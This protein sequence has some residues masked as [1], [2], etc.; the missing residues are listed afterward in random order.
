MNERA[1]VLGS[2]AQL[3]GI[4]TLP[5]GGAVDRERPALIVLNAGHVHRVGPHRLHVRLNRRVASRGFVAV[6]FD[7]S[8]IGDSPARA[9]HRPVDESAP[10]EVREVMDRIESTL[11]IR[12]FCVAGLS[13]GAVISLA[14]ALVDRRVVGACMMNP[15]VLA[16]TEEWSRHVERLSDARIYARNL[17]Q[18]VSWGKLFSGRTNYRRLARAVWYRLAPRR[19]A[20]QLERVADQARPVVDNLLKLD[21]KV[22]MVFSGKDRALEHFE[23]LLGRGWRER[24]GANAEVAILPDANHTFA[25]PADLQ[26]AIDAVESWMLRCWPA[27]GHA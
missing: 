12:R 23:A 20:S 3:V 26:G 18:P 27:G 24:L 16:P 6:R 25:R 19:D 17:L 21:T 7:F 22:L 15:Q 9:D 14:S 13:S 2:S 8:G 11:G 1:M 5:D 4:A 10:L